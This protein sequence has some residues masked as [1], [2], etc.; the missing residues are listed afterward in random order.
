MLFKQY[1]NTHNHAPDNDKE[2]QFQVINFVIMATIAIGATVLILLFFCPRFV[3]WSGL[4]IEHVWFNPEVHRAA[5]TIEQ[6]KNPFEMIPDASNRPIAWRLLL[7]IIWYGLRLPDWCFLMLPH[8]GCIFTVGLIAYIVYKQL[9]NRLL[10]FLTAVTLG[11]CPWFFVSSGWLS[12]FDSWMIAGALAVAFINSRLVL[13]LACL[14]TPWIDE[15]FLLAVPICLYVRI[16]TTGS[17]NRPASGMIRDSMPILIS[18]MTYP[19]LR[20]VLML[21]GYGGEP[22]NYVNEYLDWSRLLEVPFSRYLNGVWI[23]LRAGWVF[24]AALFWLLWNRTNKSQGYIL[25]TLLLTVTG[26]S[27]II[28]TDI[29]RTMCV[30]TPLA[31]MGVVLLGRQ[32]LSVLKIVLPIVTVANLLLPAEHVLTI[33]TLPISNAYT[34]IGQWKN[35]PIYVDPAYYVHRGVLEANR[36]NIGEALSCFDN[37]LKLDPE[38]SSALQERAKII[39]SMSSQIVLSN[40]KL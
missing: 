12:Y 17:E 33:F 14:L 40:P 36:N 13:V 20:I 28:A 7:P 24:V 2:R 37:A 11:A 1:D 19:V 10:A 25:A 16:M 18:C 31:L 8:F 9:H 34:E 3:L 4:R 6:L 15:R 5:A 22:G 32:R 21:A 35:P 38:Y 26:V 29:G 39:N 27:L 30:V 23:A